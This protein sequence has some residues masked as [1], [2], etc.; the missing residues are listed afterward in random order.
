MPCSAQAATPGSGNISSYTWDF[1]DGNTQQGY[2]AT[3]Q[4]TYTVPGKATVSLTVTNNFGC[5]NTLQKKD[6]IEILPAI[7]ASFSASQTILCREADAV[8]F[9]N[10]SYGPGTLSY[11]WDFGDGTT[12]TVKAP[13]HSFNK[14]G[15][16]TVKLT[17]TSSE[18]CIIS[19]TQVGY[20][21][22][23]SFTS[24]F[25]VPALIC[26]DANNTFNSTSTP[27]TN[28]SSW[29]VDGLPAYYYNS[30]YLNYTFNIPGNHTIK[31]KNIFGTCPDSVIKTISVKDIPYP[32]GFKDTILGNC[33]APVVVK[34]E[35]TTAGAVQ[36][37]WNFNG[38]YNSRSL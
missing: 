21:N 1:G 16:Y 28:A 9:T 30:S 32:N 33:G 20:I 27:Y 5:T 13:A 36:W 25:S 24:D 14:K 11:L 26:K 31:L 10:T 8:Q 17:V 34:F 7:N 23:A 35:D 3:Q 15:I 37:E 2:Y 12:S 22:V 6:I 4:H 19:N 18:G 29:E 38:Y